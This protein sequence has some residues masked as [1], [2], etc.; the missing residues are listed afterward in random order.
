MTR[1]AL[2]GCGKH[3]KDTLATY[4]RRLEGVGF[5]VCVDL[6]LDSALAVQ[7]KLNAKT[8]AN[9]IEAID[10]SKI[11]LAILALPPRSAFDVAKYFVNRNIPCFVEKP[12]AASTADIASLM[13]LT[14]S[15]SV[16][17]QVGFNYRF[18]DAVNVLH[19]QMSANSGGSCILSIDFKSKHPSSSEWGVEGE[20][21]PWLRHN[22][23]HAFDLLQWFSGNITKL[24]TGLFKG[25]DSRF[26]VTTFAQHSNGSISMLRI[27]N[28]T[29][30]FDFRMT[31]CNASADQIHMPHLGE[32]RMELRS[33]QL[34]GDTLYR[35]RN[36]DDGWGRAG[37]GPELEYLVKHYQEPRCSFSTLHNAAKASEL[38]DTTLNMLRKDCYKI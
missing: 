1:I 16:Y 22:G 10:T 4:L 9:N 25:S 38:C 24:S 7:A 11:D 33:G 28:L 17:V 2:V 15:R 27:G 8:S 37:Y 20:V 36:L 31:I 26:I 35:T 13:Q 14:Q 30:R 29:D 34:A 12:P 6:I 23:I 3:T 32:V 21:E 18:A 19:K 5:E